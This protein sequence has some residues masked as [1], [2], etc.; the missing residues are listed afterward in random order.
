MSALSKY[1]RWDVIAMFASIATILTFEFLGVFDPKY[2]TITAIVR[3]YVPKWARALM[4]GAFFSW[5]YYH[6]VIQD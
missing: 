6:F 2:V 4:L 1:L 5:L 3:A